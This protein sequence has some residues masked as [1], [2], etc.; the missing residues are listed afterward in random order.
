MRKIL[1]KV[2]HFIF[3]TYFENKSYSDLH[4]WGIDDVIDGKIYF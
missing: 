2:I 4:N 1:V 3:P